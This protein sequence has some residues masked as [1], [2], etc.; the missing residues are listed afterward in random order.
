MNAAQQ[1]KIEL[2]NPHMGK[3]WSI[4][5]SAT[6]PHH[7][8]PEEIRPSL[9]SLMRTPIVQRAKPFLQGDCLGWLMVEFHTDN[10]DAI[11]TAAAFISTALT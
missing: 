6:P 10:E 4:Q 5:I 3:G 11:L 7:T 8:L 9:L 2:C 1:N